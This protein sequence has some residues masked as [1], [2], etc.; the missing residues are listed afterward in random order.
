MHEV[1]T[2]MLRYLIENLGAKFPSTKLGYFVVRISLLNN[3]LTQIFELE[4]NPVGHS[5]TEEVLQIYSVIKRIQYNKIIEM[6]IHSRNCSK[7]SAVLSWQWTIV[8]IGGCHSV[9]RSQEQTF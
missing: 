5:S 1:S 7:K 4:T 2:K 8:F 6:S 3:T 9:P